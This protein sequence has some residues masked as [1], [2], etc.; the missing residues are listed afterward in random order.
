MA[1][2]GFIINDAEVTAVATSFAVAKA[3][4]LHEDSALDANSKALPQAC[5]LSH[6]ELQLDTTSGSPT[7]VSAF[8]TYDSAGDDPLT[9]VASGNSLN[10]GLTDTSLV[11]TAISMNV[12][13]RAPASQTTAGKLYL[14]IKVDAGQVTVKKARLHW[15][16][17]D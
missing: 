9:A 4:L 6:L 5:Y 7:E 15:A 17:R 13:F 10:A 11:S 3:I 14:F 8:V 12:F 2:Q 1:D 16:V